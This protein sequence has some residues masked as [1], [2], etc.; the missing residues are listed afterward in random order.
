MKKFIVT[1]SLLFAML[2]N[3]Q[4]VSAQ[5]EIETSTTAKADCGSPDLNRFFRSVKATYA[6]LPWSEVPGAKTYDVEYKLPTSATW[7][8]AAR[9]I[10]A[11]AANA[12]NE[13]TIKR[14]KPNTRY[15]WRVKTYC[16]AGSSYSNVDNFTTLFVIICDPKLSGLQ[17]T[18]VTKNSATLKWNYGDNTSTDFIVEYKKVAD[19]DNAWKKT[20][21]IIN[22]SVKISNLESNVYYLWRVKENCTGSDFD[23]IQQFLTQKDVACETPDLG[24]LFQGVNSTYARLSWI[25]ASGA[26]SYDVDYKEAGSSTWISVKKGIVA[27]FAQNN[28]NVTIN[29]LISGKTYNWRVKTI[30]SANLSNYSEPASFTTP[31]IIICDPKIIDLKTT[32]VT[33]N[34]AVLNWNY[35]DASSVGYIVEYKQFDGNFDTNW[36]TVDAIIKNSTTITNLNSNVYYIWRVKA[37]CAG[38]N[39]DIIQQ[40]ITQKDV[41][42]EQADVNR[43]FQ[44]SPTTTSV[45]RT[46]GE[47]SGAVRYNFEYKLASS[48]TWIVAATN[49]PADF[50]QGKKSYTLTGQFQVGVDYNWRVKT[51]CANLD[52]NYSEVA[53]FRVLGSFSKNDEVA[54]SIKL[55]PNPVQ[56]LLTIE[57]NEGD[58]NRIFNSQNSI[59]VI[60]TNGNT[61]LEQQTKNDSTTIDVQKLKK[62]MYLLKVISQDGQ[63]LQTQKFVK[64]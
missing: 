63:L 33:K 16:D 62:G 9:G 56:E 61:V 3:T 26:K 55:Y 64:E 31:P 28:A 21:A 5:K 12:S 4:Q 14:L 32:N 11:N 46:W 29:R 45:T 27:N 60:D 54:S 19:P 6:K 1:T 22:N 10:V 53:R 51:Y 42:C 34:S 43:F 24:L 17:T 23:E 20:D 39:F 47:A 8:V 50:A 15:D 57:L 59:I 36:K 38:S 25:E 7:I 35:G 13:A 40:F 58:R 44:T 30:C 2:C 41:P 49:L 48:S 18:N 52:N 37:N